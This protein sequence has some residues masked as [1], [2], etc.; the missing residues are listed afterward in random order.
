MRRTYKTTIALC[1][2][3]VFCLSI[4]PV[5][6]L[7]QDPF[8]TIAIGGLTGLSGAGLFGSMAGLSGID[9]SY[10]SDPVNDAMWNSINPD[11]V[12]FSGE[13][14]EAT[15]IGEDVYDYINVN[16]RDWLDAQSDFIVNFIRDNNVT[17]NDSGTAYSSTYTYDGLPIPSSGQTDIF[18]FGEGINYIGNGHFDIIEN[19]L[20]P[21][22]CSISYYNSL[23]N[24]GYLWSNTAKTS[25]PLSVYVTTT[26]IYYKLSDS[27]RWY[28]QNI[29][30][31]LLTLSGNPITYQSGTVNEN[32]FDNWGSAKVKI[33]RAISQL[34]AGW[35]VADFLD[36]LNS[37]WENNLQSSIIVEDGTNPPVPPVPIPDT[38]LGE[39]PTD[40]WMD[41]FGQH[42]LD[43]Q[44]DLGDKLDDLI[45]NQIHEGN[46]VDDIYGLFNDTSEDIIA[47]LDNIDTNIETANDSLSNIDTNIGIGNGILSGIRSVTGTIST[48]L[49]SIAE[50][51]AE[52]VES[53]VMATETLI[54]GILNQIPTVFGV[55]L[56]P[57]K[58]ASSIWHYV[59]EWLASISAPFSWIRTMVGGTSYYII[60]PVYASL[61]GTVVLAFFKRF[62]R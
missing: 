60:L 18:D 2:V 17:D 23:G 4:I 32:V 16:I 6:A 48:T 26:R 24:G 7:A 41:V 47:D 20:H 25:L 59:V 39:I 30:S 29:D 43:G 44:D 3:L 22:M 54:A 62:G 10:T 14:H 50:S 33:P 52:L 61:A 46:T 27:D 53:V 21:N 5:Q 36:E 12:Y 34:S 9:I 57:F 31:N 49:S 45:G 37:M 55:I 15:N 1:A 42:V 8:S 51:V 58:T 13:K 56:T 19:P 40:D 28:S 38:P 35:T 11:S